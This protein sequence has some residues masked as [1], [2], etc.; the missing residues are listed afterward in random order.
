MSREE[1]KNNKELWS[2]SDD[3][4]TIQLAVI[5]SEIC[6]VL[7]DRNKLMQITCIP[8]YPA[9]STSAPLN[10]WYDTTLAP[11]PIMDFSAF[12]TNLTHPQYQQ[13]LRLPR[14]TNAIYFEIVQ[15]KNNNLWNGIGTSC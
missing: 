13:D 8:S 11:C 6:I 5:G 1:Y 15:S 12:K 4:F 10:P 2:I 14:K 7:V 3:H 9:T